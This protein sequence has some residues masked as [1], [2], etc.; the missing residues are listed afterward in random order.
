MV[1][2]KER[3]H[4]EG[5]PPPYQTTETIIRW[6]LNQNHPLLEPMLMGTKVTEP[7]THSHSLSRMS[8]FTWIVMTTPSTQGVVFELEMDGYGTTTPTGSEPPSVRDA[9]RSAF[10]FPEVSGDGDDIVYPVLRVVSGVPRADLYIE[11]LPDAEASG[12]FTPSKTI[13][14]YFSVKGTLSLLAV[15][16]STGLN[17]P[18]LRRNDVI[19]IAFPQFVNGYIQSLR[20]HLKLE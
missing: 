19:Q 17:T 5:V 11:W 3:Y 14:H 10:L 16:S 7:P 1:F 20:I 6:P 15:P 8:A 18:M 13:S 9:R 4:S 12:G 2:A